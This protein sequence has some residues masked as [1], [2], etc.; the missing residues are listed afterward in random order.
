[1]LKLFLR[2]FGVVLAFLSV[3]LTGEE[4]FA[5]WIAAEA[6]LFVVLAIPLVAVI[7]FFLSRRYI[8][9][10]EVVFR[11]YVE[12]V[13]NALA[14]SAVSAFI[15]GLITVLA[16]TIYLASSGG[17]F[18]NY[19]LLFAGLFSIALSYDLWGKI[20]GPRCEQLVKWSKENQGIR[21]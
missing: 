9:N 5:G 7:W 12:P 10:G 4:S 21:D 2:I 11:A 17:I 16:G 20:M 6:M 8:L 3:A 14:S 18:S 13:F 15:A 19:F 1:M